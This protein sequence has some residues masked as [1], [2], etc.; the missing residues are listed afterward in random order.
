[1]LA[2]LKATTDAKLIH[3]WKSKAAR[4]EHV[5]GRCEVAHT[6]RVDEVAAT[7][8]IVETG[9]RGGVP[10]FRV[11]IEFAGGDLHLR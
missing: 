4:L 7:R 9:T 1:M 5:D 8:Q 2:I 3:L 6:G 11:A 10:A